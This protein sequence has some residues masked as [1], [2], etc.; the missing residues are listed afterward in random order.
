MSKK[1]KIADPAELAEFVENKMTMPG[2]V[3]PMQTDVVTGEEFQPFA[4]NHYEWNDGVPHAP[5]IDMPRLT[6]RERV[7]RL[8]GQGVDLYSR[9]IDDESE[10]GDF[11]DPDERE[12]LTPA[13][14]TYLASTEVR[15]VF[16]AEQKLKAAQAASPAQGAGVQGGAAPPA[17]SP[18]EAPTADPKP[19]NS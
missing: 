4:K 13:E 17:Q 5:P 16:T 15:E 2:E 10:E 6:L 7:A 12:P 3:L 19:S 14:T 9:G 1:N 18:V 8:Q 11:E